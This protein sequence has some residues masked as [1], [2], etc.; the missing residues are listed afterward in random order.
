LLKSNGR[1]GFG[2]ARA[3]SD[4]ETKARCLTRDEMKSA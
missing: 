3:L 2:I 1:Y 4:C